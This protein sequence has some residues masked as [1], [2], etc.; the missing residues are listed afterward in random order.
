MIITPARRYYIPLIPPN[1]TPT[2]AKPP[3]E[4]QPEESAPATVTVNP[5]PKPITPPSP[6]PSQTESNTPAD[7]SSIQVRLEQVPDTSSAIYYVNSIVK[8]PEG[9]SPLAFN[10]A[11]EYSYDFDGVHRPSLYYQLDVARLRM[12]IEGGFSVLLE[13]LSGGEID[14]LYLGDI[15]VLGRI[16]QLQEMQFY[17]GVGAR[18]MVGED[19]YGGFNGTARVNIYPGEPVAIVLVADGGNIGQ[20]TFAHLRGDFGLSFKGWEPYVGFDFMRISPVN[21]YGPLVGIRK[22]L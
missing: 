20:T 11:P 17:L 2:D 22:W 1:S 13:P 12:G 21:F 15:N 18:Y 6:S 8:P 19:T 10:L 14:V 9:T 3:R 7:D 16:V 4:A 5:S